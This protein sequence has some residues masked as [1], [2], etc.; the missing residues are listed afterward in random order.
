MLT[1]LFLK[2]NSLNKERYLFEIIINLVPLYFQLELNKF[3]QLNVTK[4]LTFFII[5]TF[6]H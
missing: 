1:S 3:T 4:L 5:I 6:I 2:I